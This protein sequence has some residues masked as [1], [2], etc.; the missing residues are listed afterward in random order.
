MHS[1]AVGE[2]TEAGSATAAAEPEMGTSAEHLNQRKWAKLRCASED[3]LLLAGLSAK[4]AVASSRWSNQG[5]C[6]MSTKSSRTPGPAAVS[7]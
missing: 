5:R 3:L 1:G 2:S 7:Q 4:P 6:H